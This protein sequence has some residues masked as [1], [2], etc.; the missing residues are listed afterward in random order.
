MSISKR[1]TILYWV[2][3]LLV[4]LPAAG[5]GIPELFASRRGFALNWRLA[6]KG[7]Q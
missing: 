1:A 6:V 3:T 7:I 2:L 4:L 5:T